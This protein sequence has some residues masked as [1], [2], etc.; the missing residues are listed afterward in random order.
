MWGAILQDDRKASPD[1]NLCVPDRFSLAARPAGYSLH[2][3]R[4]ARFV[5][6]QPVLRV[7]RIAVPGGLAVLACGNLSISHRRTPLRRSPL[8]GNLLI[9]PIPV[10]E[11]SQP[12]SLLQ[13]WK[14]TLAYDGTEF[15]GWQVQPGEVTIQGELQ[16]ALGRITGESP[17]PQGSGRTDAGVHALAQ[18]ASFALQAPIPPG[19]LLRALNRTLP[20]SIRIL[21]ARTVRSTFHARHSAVAKNYEYRVF[22]ELLCPPFLARYVFACPWPM[23]V[24]AL[25]RSARLFEGEHDFSSFAA[26][27]PELASHGVDPEAK[28]EPRPLPKLG[29]QV[30]PPTSSTVKRVFSSVWEVRKCEA[31]DLLVYRVRGNGF[32]HHMVRNLVG[33][34]LDVGRG[35][36]KVEQIP[37]IL[38]A[39][40]RSAAGPTAPARGLFL[41]SVE[42]DER[43]SALENE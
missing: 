4:S 29:F 26:T 6:A 3:A 14:L 31:G 17:L 22:R 8:S 33:T 35:R 1:A 11:F 39:R 15:R 12:A 9:G 23:D 2:Y 43:E 10:T 37:V 30:E 5:P 41:H 7:S 25:Q 16:A 28:P 42:Y 38:A 27:D 21:E 13:T 36:L 34:M 20:S 18:A 32:L 40:A 24:E 19:N